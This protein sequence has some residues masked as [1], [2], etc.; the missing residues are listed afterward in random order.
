MKVFCINDLGW[1]TGK[2]YLFGLYKKTVWTYGPKYG[3]INTVTDE[4]YLQGDLCYELM[5]WPNDNDG[6]FVASSF[7][8]LSEI[9]EME[10]INEK[11]YAVR[12]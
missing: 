4:Y 3:D 9:D 6:A 1:V 7:I 12:I 11:E 8:P 2:K 5:E 10:L